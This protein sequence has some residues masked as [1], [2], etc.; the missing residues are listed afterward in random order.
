MNKSSIRDTKYSD[1]YNICRTNWY[2]YN[3]CQQHKELRLRFNK[4]LIANRLT[5][6]M[7][8]QKK[9]EI[10]LPQYIQLINIEPDVFPLID[11]LGEYKDIYFRSFD[12]EF[13][14]NYTNNE[15]YGDIYDLTRD[16]MNDIIA[17][18]LYHFPKTR[19]GFDHYDVME[20]YWHG[21]KFNY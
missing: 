10:I 9:G 2:F 20:D 14:I 16:Q 15:N 17:A 13:L 19:I 1:L 18:H 6:K 3:L 8:S 5:G 7:I 21:I 12:D 4:Y 11:N